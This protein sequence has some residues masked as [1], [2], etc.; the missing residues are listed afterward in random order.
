MWR[1]SSALTGRPVRIMSI[2][3]EKPIRRGSRNVP[4]SISG[5]PARAGTWQSSRG[6]RVS[7]MALALLRRGCGRVP[8]R[9]Q[10][11]P[12]TA[13]CSTTR[14]SHQHASSNPPATACPATYTDGGGQGGWRLGTRSIL[15]NVTANPSPVIPVTAAITGLHSRRREMPYTRAAFVPTRPKSLACPSAAS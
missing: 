5:T 4:P 7:E 15:H 1:A 9:R 8:Q 13:D 14:R 11:T 2:A 6:W 10:K 3:R 12:K